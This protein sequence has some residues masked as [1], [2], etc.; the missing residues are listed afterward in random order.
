MNIFDP[1]ISGSLSVSGSGEISGDLRVLGTI[2]ATISG[3][4][5]NAI[6]AS[7]AAEYTLT[8]SFHQF[9]SSYTTGSFTGSFIGDG[10]GLVNIPASGVTGLNLNKIISGSVSASISPDRGFEVNTNTTVSGRITPSVDN[11]YDLGSPTHQWRDVYISSGSLYID[12]SKVLS[13]T[14]QELTITTDNGQSLKILEGTTDSIV[15][16]TADGNVELKSSADGDILLDPTNGKILLKGPVEV[17]SGQKI[18]SSVGGTPVVFANDIVVSGSIDLTGTIDGIDLSSFSSSINNLILDIDGDISSLN[19]FTSSINT[20]IKSKLDSD[21]VVSGSSQIILSGTTG[22]STVS[23]SLSSLSSSI[24]I[25]NLNQDG[26]LNSIEGKT[27]SF[28]TTGSNT[29]VGSQVISGSV[30][31]RENLIVLGSSSITYT[32]SSQLRVDDNVIVVNTSSPAERF[33]GLQVYDSGSV[34]EATG[35]LFWD[36]EKNRWVYQQSS[37]ASYGGGV[38]MSGP[39]SSGSLGDELTLT[40]GK[41][42]RSAGGDHLNDSIITE[43]NAATIGINGNLEITGSIISSVTP[44]VSGS[45]QISYTGLVNVPSGIV[46]GSSQIIYSSISSI[47]S[48]IVS[49]SSQITYSS[50]SSIPSGIVSGSSQIS[51]P[52]LSNIPGG[53]VSG[54]SQIDLTATTNYSS[55]IKTRLNAEGVISGSSQVTSIGNSQLTNSS[56]YLGSTS[57]SLGRASATLNLSSVNI[58]GYASSLNGYSNQTIY[59]ILDGPANGPVIK[60]RYDS[61][62]ANR[63]IDIGSK[64]GN[65]VYS[66]GLKLYNGSTITWLGNTVYH[67]GNIPTWNQS[68]TGN[69]ATATSADKLKTTNNQWTWSTGAHTATDPN[70]ITLWDQYSSNGGSGSPVTYGTIVDIHGRSAHEHDQLLMDSGGEIRHRNC[71]YGTDTWNGWRVMLDSS[72]VSSYALPIGGGT[73]TGS[74][75]M[76]FDTNGGATIVKGNSGGWSMGTYYKGSSDTT[77]A[78]FGAYGGGNSLTWAWIGP[79]Y[80]SPWMT[81]NSSNTVFYNSVLPSSNGT[82]NLG[83]SS[84]RWNTVFTSDLS[85]SNGIGD[86]TI[87]EGENDLFLYNNKQN[88]VYKFMLQ[89]VNPNDATPKRPE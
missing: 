62:T 10:A 9:T 32:T 50:I 14:T 58:D 30:T 36:S 80:E 81:I 72:N 61:A 57:V 73:L 40:S 26:R 52:S 75:P 8:S 29:F 25:T 56:F 21:G 69:A 88:K 27:G 18:Q 86:Y 78:G 79:G 89:E 65:G 42:A 38:L 59:T 43:Y 64:D 11:E 41:I 28:A 47:P 74:R 51:Y 60:V 53:I 16:Q 46:S 4:T 55:G 71:F 3:T 39:R 19:S 44:L 15:L 77:L 87:V 17:L 63:Y 6:S 5:S 1:H 31:I 22:F 37:E 66:E 20:T 85:L 70:S 68:T 83:S 33:G 82:L 76:T 13:S 7:H 84:A 48:G 2:N 45:S 24:S 54:S 49:G 67:S 23:A 35:S 12:G 34:G